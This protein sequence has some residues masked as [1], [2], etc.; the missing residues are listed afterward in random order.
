MDVQSIQT[1]QNIKHE[2]IRHASKRCYAQRS[3][4]FVVFFSILL[5][6]RQTGTDHSGPLS[7]CAI[8]RRMVAN[9]VAARRNTFSAEVGPA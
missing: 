1:Q 8:M 6:Y 3:C 7:P 5:D 9:H 4:R 2:I